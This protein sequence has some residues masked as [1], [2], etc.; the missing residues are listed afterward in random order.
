RF[1]RRLQHR[2]GIEADKTVGNKSRSLLFHRDMTG[3]SAI[4]VFGDHLPYPLFNTN[5]E[6][7]TNVHMFPR[8]TQTHDTSPS[9]RFFIALTNL[10]CCGEA[11]KDIPYNPCE[12]FIAFSIA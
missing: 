2:T 6:S 12:R 7:V 4:E 11:S 10:H 1:A 8:Y 3:I 9:L 5:A